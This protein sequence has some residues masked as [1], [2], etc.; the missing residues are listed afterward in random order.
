MS[1]SSDDEGD[2]EGVR[3]NFEL[4]TKV[5]EAALIAMFFRNEYEANESSVFSYMLQ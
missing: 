3:A 1:V 2:A 4:L 5:F